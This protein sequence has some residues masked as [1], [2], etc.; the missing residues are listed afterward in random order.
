VK[1]GNKIEITI[2][3]DL[4]D[5]VPGY[6]DS[7]KK[8]L[9]VLNDALKGSHFEKIETLGHRMKGVAISYGFSFLTDLGKEMELAAKEKNTKT[10]ER[11]IKDITEY[12][13]LIEIKYR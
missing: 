1:K 10:L 7:V 3:L 8:D 2:D 9:I 6:L 12:L 5:I 13:D 11:S 4:Q